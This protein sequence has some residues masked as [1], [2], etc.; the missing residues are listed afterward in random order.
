MANGW[1]RGEGGGGNDEAPGEEI[2]SGGMGRSAFGLMRRRWRELRRVKTKS[3]GKHA[4]QGKETRAS[5]TGR[6]RAS[7]TG[8]N[9]STQH[10]S[11]TWGIGPRPSRGAQQNS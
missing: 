3:A 5:E 2:R 9:G 1:G 6:T 4:R 7:E 11:I 8:R 10:A